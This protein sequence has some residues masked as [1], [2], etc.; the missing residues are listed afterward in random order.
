MVTKKL[1]PILLIAVVLLT[2]CTPQ[3]EATPVVTS[4]PIPTLTPLPPTVVSSPTVETSPLE[5]KGHTSDVWGVDFSPD[6]KYLATGS[7]D[8][9]ARLWDVATGETIRIFSGIRVRS[10]G[11]NSRQTANTS[12]REAARITPPSCGM[13]P[14]AKPCRSSPGTLAALMMLPS[15]RME[16]SLSP[17]AAKIRRP[18]SG[19]LPQGK[20][21]T[22][23]AAI[24]IMCLVWLSLPMA[25]TCSLLEPATGLRGFGMPRRARR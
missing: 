11:S 9:T 8:K 6:G 18:A 25:N 4:A 10:M 20:L 21:C 24:P 19:I 22:F 2:A 17:P 5:F 23:L 15:R 12:W 1:L 7:S 3:V 16:N 14:A 13:L